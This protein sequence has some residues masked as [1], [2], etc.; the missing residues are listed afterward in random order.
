MR[1]DNITLQSR[2][3][4][5]VFDEQGR[6]YAFLYENMKLF[7]FPNEEQSFEFDRSKKHILVVNFNLMITQ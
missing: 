1:F 7:V 5:Y 6:K 3:T 4:G 2:L